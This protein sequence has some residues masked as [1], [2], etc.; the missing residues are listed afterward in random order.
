M[1]CRRQDRRITSNSP[2]TWR[3][4]MPDSVTPR[5]GEGGQPP[6]PHPGAGGKPAAEHETD[7]TG[8]WGRPERDTVRLGAATVEPGT[9]G[10][11]AGGEFR[12]IGGDDDQAGRPVR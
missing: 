10:V 1:P 4:N 6:P 8:E 7:L 3:L 11:R 12:A 2:A 5:V 9:G